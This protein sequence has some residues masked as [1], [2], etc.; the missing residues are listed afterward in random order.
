MT[1]TEQVPSTWL[2]AGALCLLAALA[3]L[4]ISRTPVTDPT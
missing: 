3:C 1:D 4:A 2:T